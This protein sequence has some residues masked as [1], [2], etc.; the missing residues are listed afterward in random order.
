MSSQ[1]AV[2]DPIGGPLGPGDPRG[3]WGPLAEPM[4]TDKEIGPDDPPWRENIFLSFADRAQRC[5]VIAHLQGGKTDAG[6]CARVTV[7]LDDHQFEIFEPLGEM[8]WSSE[9][10]SFD[11]TGPLRA[12]SDALRVELSMT[13]VREPVDYSPSAALPGLRASEPL[14]HLEQAGEFTGTVWTPRG[15]LT[16]S[17][18]VIRDRTWGWRQ[19]IASWTEYYAAF[20]SFDSF[21]LAAMKFSTRDGDVPAHGSL[22]GDRRGT[23]TSSSV[24]RRDGTGT[25]RELELTLADGQ[26]LALSLGAPEARIF[27]P[28]NEPTGPVAFTAYDDLVEVRLD[29][30]SVGFGIMEQGILR[31]QA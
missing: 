9:H 28:L 18:S 11:P 6:M 22:V 14:R 2:V 16:V 29:D 1:V 7:V 31:T 23:V 12:S 4:H 30:G 15:E 25:I 5:F 8:T 26:S 10:V 20:I 19:E 27:C 3:P 17:G 13:P 24:K 21:D